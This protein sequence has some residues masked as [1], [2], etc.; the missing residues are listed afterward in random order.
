MLKKLRHKKTAKKIWIVL[1]LLIVPAFVFW[2]FG[3]F[4]RNKQEATYVGIIY[5]K[6]ITPLQYKDA[7]DAVKNQAIIQFGD[8]LSEIEKNLNLESQAWER[9]ILLAEAKKRKINASDK[10]VVELIQGY[11]FFLDKNGRFNNQVYSQ[12][13]QYVFRTQPRVFE[14]QARQNLAISKLYKKLTDD[15]RISEEIT[16]QEYEK[17]NEQIDLYYIAAIPADFI[18]EVNASE[19]GLKGY[20]TKNPLK[21]KQPVSFNIEYLSLPAKDTDEEATQD[22]IKKLFWRLNKREDFVKVAKA[23]GLEIKETGFFSQTDPIPGIGWSPQIFSLIA[24]LK[25]GEF[26]PPIRMDKYY[27][28]LKLKERKESYIPDFLAIKDKVEEEF[29]RD[30][31]QEIA[32]EKIENCLKKLRESYPDK[33]KAAD[34]NK[35]ADIYGLKSKSTGMF[36]YGGYIE[37][38]GV[39]D[40]LFTAALSLKGK[41]FSQIIKMPSGFYIIRLKTKTPIDEAKF[42][43]EKEEFAKRLLLQKKIEYFTAFIEESKRKTQAF[44]ENRLR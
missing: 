21:F 15:I 33:S 11:P 31:S 6:K 1:I 20:F 13:L 30:K 40:T 32:Q 17:I 43:E 18:K 27:Y 24:K 7:L 5:G 14:E 36:K 39:S 22:K 37:G 41:E 26:S 23:F 2:G 28:I 8:N 3:S 29:I 25:T 16:R 12:M 4:M 44:Q 34:F 38:V 19:E 35:A 42:K 9:L 10:E